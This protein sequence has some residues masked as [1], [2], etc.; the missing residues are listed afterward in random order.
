M[1]GP[2]DY[3]A[4]FSV[5]L[6]DYYHPQLVR[7][8][9]GSGRL[10]SRVEASTA[11][12][13]DLLERHGVRATFF[14]VGEVARDAPR[15]IERI[16]RGGHEIGCH[17]YSH[18]PLWDMTPESF[19]EDLRRFKAEIK[20][21][22]GDVPVR[23]F[24]APTFSLDEGTSWA[25][26][27]LAEEG[28]TYDSSLV[29]ARGPLYGCPGAPVGIYRP[30][31][32]D[33]RRPDPRGPL[34]EFPA[35]VVSFA[36]QRFPVG[37]GIYLRALPFRVYHALVRRV[38]KRRPFF[39]Y[40]HPWETDPDIPK[41]DLPRFARWATYTGI[42]GMLKRIE[43]LLESIRFTTMGAAIELGAGRIES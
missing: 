11:P 22:A 32:E 1:P 5:D 7:G 42:A 34:V 29:P 4:A 39:L 14:I 33:L 3:P 26:P 27:I 41:F 20:G 21:A 17:T 13:L 2:Q 10:A 24:R 43:R 23:G 9:T 8:H 40:I 31:S 38:L 35:P 12:I 16:V 36:R 19:R 25:L 6:E 28:F 18:D 30:S 15:L 37:G